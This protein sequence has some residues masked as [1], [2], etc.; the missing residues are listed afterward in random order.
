MSEHDDLQPG[1]PVGGLR[2]WRSA[3]ER[4]PLVVD[5]GFW[6]RMDRVAH[7]VTDR[8]SEVVLRASR[9][10][11][12]TPSRI[13]DEQRRRALADKLITLLSLDTMEARDEIVQMF[14]DA[15][16]A[17][18]APPNPSPTG[19]VVPVHASGVPLR[20]QLRHTPPDCD[21]PITVR[22]QLDQSGVVIGTFDLSYAQA[23]ALRR[24]LEAMLLPAAATMC[25]VCLNRGADPPCAFCGLPLTPDRAT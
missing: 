4:V 10:E 20:A 17:A 14:Y 12:C 5:E 7:G 6:Q 18:D 24:D 13:A 8:L 11:P 16:K 22:A 2:S 3:R 25:T 23:V 9:P 21:Y 19:E 1:G 15:T